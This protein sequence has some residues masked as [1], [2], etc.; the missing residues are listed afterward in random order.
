MLCFPNFSSPASA[1]E[2]PIGFKSATHGIYVGDWLLFIQGK[3]IASHIGKKSLCPKSCAHLL[4]GRPLFNSLL[5]FIKCCVLCQIPILYEYTVL[6]QLNESLVL[7]M[8]SPPYSLIFQ[9][10]PPAVSRQDI[11]W[12]V[13]IFITVAH[14]FVLTLLAPKIMKT[15]LTHDVLRK[16][17][18]RKKKVL[19]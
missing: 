2:A 13:F 3:L 16:K 1:I 9:S 8:A 19:W 15:A 4:T 6:G 5:I 12:N 10:I 14:A 17:E 7:L 11:A 18:A